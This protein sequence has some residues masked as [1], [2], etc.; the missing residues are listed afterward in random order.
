MGI[1]GSS[2]ACAQAAG[3]ISTQPAGNC[4]TNIPACYYFN[5][6]QCRANIACGWCTTSTQGICM[7]GDGYGKFVCNGFS[8]NGTWSLD[9]VNSEQ[10][11]HHSITPITSGSNSEFIGI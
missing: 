11:T 8:M 10:T 1:S 4:G 2:L 6:T 9:Q 7:K 3:G 5:E